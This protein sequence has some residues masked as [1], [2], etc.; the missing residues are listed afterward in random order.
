MTRNALG[1]LLPG[2]LFTQGRS[3][4][5][6]SRALT[7]LRAL[8]DLWDGELVVLSPE[9]N[10]SAPGSGYDLVSSDELP[11]EVRFVPRDRAALDAFGLDLVTALHSPQMDFVTGARTPVVLTSEVTRSIRQGI[12]SAHLRGIGKARAAVGLHR[13]ERMLRQQMVAARSAQFNGYP[14]QAAYAQLT[15][16]S[17]GFFDHRVLAEDVAAARATS[18]WDGSRPLRMAFSGRLD[19]I[20]GPEY[21]VDLARRALT[22]GLPVEL[23]VFGTGPMEQGLTAD[24]PSNVHFEGFKD[25]R[26]EWLPT[27]REQIDLMVL[28]HV[29]G[30][31]A[32]TY[33]EALGSGAPVLGFANEALDP[34]VKAHGIGWVAPMFD[35]GGLLDRLRS[36]LDNPGELAGAR[37]KGLDLVEENSFEATNRRRADHLEKVSMDPQCSSHP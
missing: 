3:H 4:A 29:Q 25:F 2:P 17:I 23:H 5:F 36:L 12:Q 32:C 26:S 14:A 22:I 15:R 19:P 7:G 16:N 11:F 6:E 18:P 13:M 35:V 24:A 33:F 1:H 20:K 27:V 10:V 28:P 30:D 21:A 31:P 8:A 37:L 9:G 34:L